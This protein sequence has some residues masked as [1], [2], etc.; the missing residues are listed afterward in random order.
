[1]RKDKFNL[2]DLELDILQLVAKGYNN[3]DIAKTL[4]VST[5]TVKAH[6]RIIFEKL[7]VNNR[8]FAVYI[9]TKKR[10]ID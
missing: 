2:S 5:H 8:A 1:M 9:A 10:L 4:Y 7:N 3:S 6:L